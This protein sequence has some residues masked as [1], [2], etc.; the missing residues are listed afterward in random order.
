[1]RALREI[2]IV[3]DHPDA[4]ELLGGI[5]RE[6]FP[7]AKVSAAATAAEALAL[8]RSRPWDLALVD[9][10]LPDGNGIDVIATL[11]AGCPQARIVVSSIYGD[12]G[13]L[14]PALQAGAHGYLL[15]DEPRDALLRQ[16]T[17]MIDGVPPLSPAI[18]R[19]LIHH[20]QAPALKA[21]AE[22]RLSVREQEALALLARG[23]SVKSL[24]QTMGISPHTAS[25]YVKSIYRKLNITS[26]A[27]A[28]LKANQLGLLP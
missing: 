24:A 8:A 21:P 13:H 26:R 9:L 19:K 11:N 27:E 22:H 12:D 1:M 15:K 10:H 23:V 18:A 3:E 5:V 17:G 16:L 6:A 28:A 2:L 7:Q 20:F 4:Q 25:D 14:F